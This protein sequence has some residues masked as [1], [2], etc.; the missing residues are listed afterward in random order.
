MDG[1]QKAQIP[2]AWQLAVT[3]LPAACNRH[4]LPITMLAAIL[5]RR[6]WKVQIQHI[7]ALAGAAR[8]LVAWREVV[9]NLSLVASAL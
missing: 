7:V 2:F 8:T 5:G 9:R 1:K 6:L 4:V 3:V